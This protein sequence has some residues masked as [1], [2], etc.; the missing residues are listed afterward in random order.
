MTAPD[1]GPESVGLVH[2]YLLVARG[3]ER[4]FASIADLWPDA[5]LYTTLLAGD[6]DLPALAGRR[7]TTSPLQRVGVGQRGF[8]KL[9]PLYPW[10]VRSL[11][12]GGHDLVV[13]SSSAFAHRA[14]IAPGAVHVCYCHTPF[15]YAWHERERALAELPRALRPALSRVLGRMR[16]G[17]VAAAAG[18]D[19]LIANSELTRERIGRFW[20][21]ESAVVHPPVEVGRF[22][23]GEPGE[24]LLV[25]C[26]LVRH[27]RVDLALEAARLA[28]VPIVVVGSGPDAERLQREFAD[29]SARFEGRID[30]E[31]LAEL[32]STC[33]ALVVPN[34][35]E[36]GIAMVEAQAAGRPV[37]AVDG[38]GAREIVI[39]GRTGRL[40]PRA[41]PEA[42]AEAI[43]ATPADALDPALARENATRFAPDRFA[44]R[45]RAEVDSAWRA[46]KRR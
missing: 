43:S 32:Y 28:G 14:R 17:D 7:I 29:G 39:D 15:R 24:H 23:P 37:V 46:R 12:V 20:G 21:R 19:H 9:L 5:P 31:R 34:V 40:V 22:R 35:E 26:E 42:L 18:V 3:A 1:E 33:R 16:R 25:V 13:S 41:E 38:G 30:D 27:K 45:L 11:P 36:F 8:R 6:L 44:E 10:A 4:T 2:D